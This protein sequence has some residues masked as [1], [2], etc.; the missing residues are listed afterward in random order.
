MR[1]FC[2]VVLLMFSFIACA[3]EETEV[4]SPV[5]EIPQAQEQLEV[6]VN[7]MPVWNCE[8]PRP[9]R[10]GTEEKPVCGS[11]KSEYRNSC[12]ACRNDAVSGYTEGPCV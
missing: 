9:T 11:D 10:C 1:I 4:V 8:N 6:V 2:I 3:T 5:Q 7:E 12:Y